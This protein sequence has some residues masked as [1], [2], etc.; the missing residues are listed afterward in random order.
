MVGAA[1]WDYD[2]GEIGFPQ[3]SAFDVFK[4]LTSLEDA[5]IDVL[6]AVFST[7]LQDNMWKMLRLDDD[8]S[9]FQAVRIGLLLNDYFSAE[10]IKKARISASILTATVNI[11]TGKLRAQLERI[12]YLVSQA[13]VAEFDSLY[14][15][16]LKNSILLNIN[17]IKSI[18]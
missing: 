18:I 9:T 11:N 16:S 1:I 13:P 5:S 4:D 10:N 17:R 7:I 2:L 8:D 12:K 6:A 15:E 14:Y 3:I